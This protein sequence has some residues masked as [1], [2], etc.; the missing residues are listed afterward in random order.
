MGPRLILGMAEMAFS[1]A[2]PGYGLGV[3]HTVR[4]Q[5]R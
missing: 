1:L 2:G 4:R 5:N 3:S